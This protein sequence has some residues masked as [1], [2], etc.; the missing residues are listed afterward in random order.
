MSEPFSVKT[1]VRKVS[2]LLNKGIDAATEVGSRIM[3]VLVDH[4]D[5][6]SVPEMPGVYEGRPRNAEEWSEAIRTEPMNADFHYR[7]ARIHHQNFELTWAKL[8]Y[9]AANLTR[10]LEGERRFYYLVLLD[11]LG[12]A[13]DA[14]LEEIGRM[15]LDPSVREAYPEYFL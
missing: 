8:E 11:A 1:L 4:F 13:D 6:Y 2:P 3:G 14:V 5:D 7:L 15:D 9:E 12:L 10:P